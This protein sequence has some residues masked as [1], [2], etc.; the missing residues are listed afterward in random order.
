VVEIQCQAVRKDGSTDDRCESFLKRFY[1]RI[2]NGPAERR[3]AKKVADAIEA[4]QVDV[5]IKRQDLPVIRG[6]LTQA[7]ARESLERAAAACD[8]KWAD[9]YEIGCAE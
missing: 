4:R 5:S 1:D 3:D 9:L 2:E 8:A 6:D 7:E